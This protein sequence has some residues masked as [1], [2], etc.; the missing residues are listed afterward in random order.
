[1][2]RALFV[3]IVFLLGVLAGIAVSTDGDEKGFM[4]AIR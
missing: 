2:I 3:A 4:D 1:M